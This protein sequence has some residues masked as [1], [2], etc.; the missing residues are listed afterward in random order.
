MTI[1]YPELPELSP[2][3]ADNV[4]VDFEKKDAKLSLLRIRLGP[5]GARLVSELMEDNPRPT[6]EDAIEMVEAIYVALKTSSP[7]AAICCG[8]QPDQVGSLMAK[9]NDTTWAPAGSVG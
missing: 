9:L 4:R 1:P 7:T 6:I 2:D 8:A 5:Y 3:F